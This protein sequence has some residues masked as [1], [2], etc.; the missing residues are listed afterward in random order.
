M[1]QAFAADSDATLVTAAWR[2]AATALNRI[3]DV[4]ALGT[5]P[6]YPKIDAASYDPASESYRRLLAIM[7]TV[8]H[9]QRDDLTTFYAPSLGF[10]RRLLDANRRDEAGRFEPLHDGENAAALRRVRSVRWV[11][12]PYA[13]IVVPGAGSDRPD[14][15]LDPWGKLRLELA[16]ARFK[17]GTAPFLIVSG[18]Y[19]HP[20]QTPFNEALEM[21]RSLVR[22]FGV[23]PE[24]VIIDPHARHTTTNLRNA[25]R[26]A[27]RYGLPSGT[28][29]LITSDQGQSAYIS[30]QEFHDRCLREMGHL[31]G[32][33]GK[34]LSPFDQE[35]M[36]SVR[37]LHADARDP[38]DP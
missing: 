10:A 23:P 25:A 33:L 14:V 7:A 30:G 8:M 13:A 31:P 15:A 28:P 6:L 27:L 38:L 21:K 9:D 36:P 34:R 20:N 35:F 5:A 17:A 37:A 4:Y 26:L 18:G 3:V 16:V 2:D 1:F 32:V 19:V 11:D 22:D 24:A 29:L 12:F